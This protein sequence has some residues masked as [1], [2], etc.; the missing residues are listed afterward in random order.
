MKPAEHRIIKADSDFYIY[1]PSLAGRTA[2]FHPLRSGFFH[3]ETG[4][5]Q[6]RRRFDSF[7]LMYV[8]QGSMSLQLSSGEYKAQ[9]GQ[10]ILLDCY[11]YHAYTALE[12]SKVLWLHFDGPA[13]RPY[14]SLA[15]SQGPVITLKDP[16]PCLD[17]L[18]QVYQGFAS[19]E[20]V[21]EALLS[22]YITDMLTALV[23]SAQ[24]KKL[25]IKKQAQVIEDAMAY[26]ADH[27][28]QKLTI[29][30]LSA[31]ACMSSYYFIHTFKKQTGY[32]PH[33]Y[34]V[35]SRVHAAQYWL[36][37]S[38]YS[39]KQIAQ[40]SGFSDTS[41]FCAGFKKKIGITP[42]RYRQDHKQQ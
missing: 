31:H 27:L 21:N 23:L 22:K 42:L 33:A 40:K 17:R 19:H 35:N 38:D 25:D 9:Q 34:I 36:V 4:Y 5:F 32:T 1:T 16:T 26:I 3:Y 24:N 6:E 39:L 8:D 12:D 20:S 10:F 28:E 2:F 13:A 29:D 7:L 14:W 18:K 15:T 41:A 30:E 11:K 37:N